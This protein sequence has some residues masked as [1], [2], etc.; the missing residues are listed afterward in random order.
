MKNKQIPG[1]PVLGTG[2]ELPTYILTGLLLLEVLFLIYA[3]IEPFIY[4]YTGFG[5]IYEY[6]PK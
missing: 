6:A 2:T 1:A 3:A 5:F 4:F